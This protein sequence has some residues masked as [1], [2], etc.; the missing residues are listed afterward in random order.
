MNTSPV[1]SVGTPPHILFVLAPGMAPHTEEGTGLGLEV[2]MDLGLV[3]GSFLGLTPG[4]EK[5]ILPELVVDIYLGRGPDMRRHT[6]PQLVPGTFLGSFE[7]MGVAHMVACT[8]D[9]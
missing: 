7:D 5:H 9:H 6:H 8:V 1:P 2:D 4:T 3:V